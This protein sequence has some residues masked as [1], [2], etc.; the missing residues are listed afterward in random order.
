MLFFQY[1][2][3]DVFP[4]DFGM[5]NSAASSIAFVMLVSLVSTYVHYMLVV[6][7]VMC[8]RYSSRSV[9][10][11]SHLFGTEALSWMYWCCI[12]SRTVRWSLSSPGYI[13]QFVNGA[14]SNGRSE[15]SIAVLLIVV[16]IC[17]WY[18]KKKLSRC[19]S[20]SLSKRPALLWYLHHISSLA[21][22]SPTIIDLGFLVSGVVISSSPSTL[23]NYIV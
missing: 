13:D 4:D 19:W 11:V 6:V 5:E 16:Q 21:L 9:C 10:C 22:K 20:C 3:A 14:M 23:Y 15:R 2:V 8:S 18:I 17:G 12:S 1:G 7:V